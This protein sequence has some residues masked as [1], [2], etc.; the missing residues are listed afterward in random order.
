M[1]PTLIN[2]DVFEPIKITKNQNP[3]LHY[4]NYLNT[5]HL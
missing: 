4:D 1:V 5:H 2:K 3:T